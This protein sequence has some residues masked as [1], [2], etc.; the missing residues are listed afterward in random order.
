M[1]QAGVN[2]KQIN[3]A[4]QADGEEHISKQ[5]DL[6]HLGEAKT[7]VKELF[8]MNANP[9][10]TLS[11]KQRVAILNADQRCIFDK[12]K[13]NLHQQHKANECSCDLSLLCMFVSGGGRMGVIPHQNHQ[14]I[15][16]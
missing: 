3:N 7:A 8:H 5:Q 10:D 1:L 14:G 2:I 4:W 6:Q 15:C 9:A 12:V 11:L 13:Y 16:S